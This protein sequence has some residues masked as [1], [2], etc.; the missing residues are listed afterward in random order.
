MQL[1]LGAPQIIY[2]GG[3]LHTRLRYFDAD[4]QRPGLPEDVAA[5]VER[6]EADRTVVTLV[7][8]SPFAHR[9]VIVQAGG[10]G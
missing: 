6:L 8:I 10:F 1:T 5:L 7:N 3:L 4:Q 9:T 2:N